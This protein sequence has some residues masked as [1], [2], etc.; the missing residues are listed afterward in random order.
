MTATFITIQEAA[1]I[2]GKSIQTIRRA[3][4]G[5]KV[6]SRKKK[7][8]Q[9]YN[10]AVDRD[11]L[12]K[13]YRIKLDSQEKNPSGLNKKSLK[14]ADLEDLPTFR[15]LRNI[16]KDIEE[17]MDEQR[18]TKENFMRFMKTFQEKFVLL[19]N[20]LKLLEEPKEK[21]WYHFWK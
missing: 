19:E 14:L 1:E 16:Q 5:K 3:I 4:K 9:G 11:S 15:D 21:K 6:T 13:F 7:T 17:L 8:P 10:Y 12:F 20:Q 18:K 2:S